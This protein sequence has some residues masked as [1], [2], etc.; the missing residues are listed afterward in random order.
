MAI[1]ALP[2]HVRDGNMCRRARFWDKVSFICNTIMENDTM[3][4]VNYS[5]EMTSKIVADYEAG[6][7]V[8]DIALS[9]DRSVRSVRSKLV[10]EGVYKAAERLQ[11]KRWGHPKK[12]S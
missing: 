8:E 4:K 12:N 7:P 3:S 1:L 2:K 6:L 9:V 11:P 5:E 10:R